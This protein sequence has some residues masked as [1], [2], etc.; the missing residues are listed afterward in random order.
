MSKR[1]P[2]NVQRLVRNELDAHVL[3]RKAHSRAILTYFF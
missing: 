1:D 2:E 3:A